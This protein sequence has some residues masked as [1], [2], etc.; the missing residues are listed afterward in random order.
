VLGPSTAPLAREPGRVLLVRPDHIGDVLLTAPAVALLRAGLP[1][2]RLTYL[3][4]PWSAEAAQAGPAVDE[5]QTLAF[6]G[7]TRR[8][9]ANVLAP[10]ALLL[11][12]AARLRHERFDLAVVFRPDHWWGAL[13]ALTAG[14]PLRVGGLT[15]ETQPLLT[16]AYAAS[17]SEHAA[18]QA[19]GTAA[20]ALTAVN[21]G[22]PAR[23]EDTME[24]RFEGTTQFSVT[25]AARSDAAALW[26]RLGLEGRVVVGIHPSAGA[27]LKS[28]PVASWARLADALIISER[29]AVVLT[30]APTDEPLIEAIR[31]CMSQSAVVACGQPLAVSAAMY[32]RC[33]VVV[34]VDS[35]AGHLAAAVGTPTVRLYG[36]APPAVFGA[37]PC[38]ADQRVLISNV[39]SCIP[40]G[41]LDSP[42][43]GARELPACMLAL[44]VDDV[45]NAIRAELVHG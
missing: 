30:G 20:L 32:E 28:W 15:P 42:P 29:V 14:I 8:R 41:Q 4:G 1:E 10:Y 25:E 34:S 24:A 9:S 2:A 45:L 38:R 23:L 43:C 5:V 21:V 6:P 33:A 13:L 16:S 17:V 22:V 26:Q 7:F 36:P 40:C 3:V 39:L 31:G 12:E 11:R 18:Q 35:G 27:P 19:L 44:S 37:W